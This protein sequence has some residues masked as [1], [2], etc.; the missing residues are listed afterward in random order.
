MLV[1]THVITLSLQHECFIDISNGCQPDPEGPESKTLPSAYNKAANEAVH[2][3][4]SLIET[5]EGAS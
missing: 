3:G 1:C 5:T 2:A 4:C